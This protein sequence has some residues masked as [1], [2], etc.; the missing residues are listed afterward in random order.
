[1]QNQ[2]EKQQQKKI[3]CRGS[4]IKSTFMDTKKRDGQNNYFTGRNKEN[5]GADK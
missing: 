4:K 1:M 2:K 5:T 3:L